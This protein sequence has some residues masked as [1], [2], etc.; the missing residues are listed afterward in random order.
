MTPDLTV[1]VTNFGRPELLSRCLESVVAAGCSNIVVSS[2]CPDAL[3]LEVLNAFSERPGISFFATSL[4]VD[5]GVNELWL[6]G[7]YYAQSKYVLILHDDDHLH[8]TFGQHW[9]SMR[10]HLEAG[11]GLVSW[12]G[13]LDTPEGPVASDYFEGPTRS[14][15]TAALSQVCLSRDKGPVSPVVSVFRRTDAIRFLKEAGDKLRDPKQFTRLGMLLGNELLLYLRVCEKYQSWFYLDEVL[16]QYGAH[17]GSETWSNIQSGT[18]EKLLSGY[19]LTRDYFAANRCLRYKPGPRLLHVASVFEPRDPETK[20]RHDFA[21]ATWEPFY[22]RGDALP[23]LV[24]DEMLSRSS[25][26]ELGDPRPVPFLRDLFDWGCAFAAPEDIV[27]FSN[28]D[29]GAVPSLPDRLRQHF[30]DPARGADFAWRHN[31]YFPLNGLVTR[32]DNGFKDGGV[33]LVAFRPGWWAE[34]RDFMPDM[35]IGCEAWDWVLRLLIEEAHP[36]LPVGIDGLIF[37]EWHDPWNKR[38][39]NRTSNPGN[40]YNVRLGTD[41]FS[42][43]G[44]PICNLG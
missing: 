6:R 41:F 3:V 38:P 39:A 36:G 33:D 34:H 17:D 9:Q 14:L 5:L 12:R 20:R 22:A 13:V 18:W 30:A 32:C 7:I 40:A 25:K 4:D 43:R 27:I 44:E 23:L 10:S 15:S 11:A 2:M 26:T 29:I 8:P 42:K 21:A 31:Y 24:T 1:V 28:A 37:H 19:N 16:T 35:L